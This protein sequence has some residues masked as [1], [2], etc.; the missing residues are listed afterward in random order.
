MIDL[1]AL[2]FPR[3]LDCIII[4]IKSISKYLT[5]ANA[6][7]IVYIRWKDQRSKMEKV[8]FSSC[9]LQVKISNF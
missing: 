8:I 4:S 2:A 7:H 6:L 5:V 3:R 9:E 1:T